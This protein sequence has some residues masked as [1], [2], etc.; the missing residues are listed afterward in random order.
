MYIHTVLS[1][2]AYT[3]IFT[4][5]S[6]MIFKSNLALTASN[7]CKNIIAKIVALISNSY[8]FC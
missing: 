7:T 3:K 2:F 6:F 4:K 1:I 5:S 8:Y